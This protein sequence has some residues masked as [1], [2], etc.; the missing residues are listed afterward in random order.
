MLGWELALRTCGLTDKTPKLLERFYSGRSRA[1]PSE[2]GFDSSKPSGDLTILQNCQSVRRY[3]GSKPLEPRPVPS[4]SVARPL[5]A[6]VYSVPKP[7]PAH[8]GSSVSY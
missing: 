2:M 3:T 8:Q 5:H 7:H 6:P 1:A 4:F